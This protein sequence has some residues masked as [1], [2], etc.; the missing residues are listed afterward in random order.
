MVAPKFV[1]IYG[2]YKY[3][4]LIYL[5]AHV[6]RRYV[7]IETYCISVQLHNCWTKLQGG[8]AGMNGAFTTNWYIYKIYTPIQ[9]QKKN[10]DEK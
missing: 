1:S 3:I 7:P 2:A 9:S 8:D 10:Q 4:T 6:I 5:D